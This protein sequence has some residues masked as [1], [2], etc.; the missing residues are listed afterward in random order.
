M[1]RMIFYV[2]KDKI[3]GFTQIAD[4]Y[5]LDTRL[6]GLSEKHE[7]RIEIIYGKHERAAMFDLVEFTQGSEDN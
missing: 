1:K 7:I 5:K 6:K 2:P 3:E 4:T